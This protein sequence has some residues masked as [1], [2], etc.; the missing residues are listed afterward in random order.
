MLVIRVYATSMV[1]HREERHRMAVRF[2]HVD[3]MKIRRGSFYCQRGLQN[4][5][6]CNNHRLVC[7]QSR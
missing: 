1:S 3:R 6:T 5:L 4:V 7:C 2:F